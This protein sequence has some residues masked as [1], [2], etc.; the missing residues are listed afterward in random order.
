MYLKRELTVYHAK[1][2]EQVCLACNDLLISERQYGVCYLEAKTLVTEKGN[3]TEE[4]LKE[5]G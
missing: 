5:A 1:V 2:K 4:E 3:V